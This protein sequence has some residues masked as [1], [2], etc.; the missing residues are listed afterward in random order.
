MHAARRLDKTDKIVSIFVP[1]VGYKLDSKHWFE[2]W[3]HNSETYSGNSVNV[4]FVLGNSFIVHLS[5]WFEWV[6]LH[7]LLSFILE[8]LRFYV[9]IA[10]FLY[11]LYKICISQLH[12]LMSTRAI[13]MWYLCTDPKFS[14]SRVS[15][16]RFTL[17]V[18][19]SLKHLSTSFEL[20]SCRAIPNTSIH[21]KIV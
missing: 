2:Q 5:V 8:R 18:I 1:F 20:L 19:V 14:H 6:L 15:R 16:T 21:S 3:M 4:Q 10:Q 13:R 9:C 11:E 12:G 7:V 17:S